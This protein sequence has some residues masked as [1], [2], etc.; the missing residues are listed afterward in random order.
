MTSEQAE[1]ADFAESTSERYEEIALSEVI[2]PVLGKTPKRKD[3]ENWGGDIKWASAKDISQNK[4]RRIHDTE[5]KMT[6]KGK[7]ESNAKI[8]PEGT[9]VVVARGATMGRA[10]QLGEPMTF[11]QTC[12]GLNANSSLDDDFLYYA[13]KYKFN[14]IQAV[15]HGTVFDT[16]TMDSFNDIDI[17][18][19]EKQIQRKIASVLRSIDNKIEVN[20]EIRGILEEMSHTLFKN[21]FVNFSPYGS[22][23]ETDVGKIPAGFQLE[24][25]ED[26]LS[27]QRGYSYSGD[28]LIDEESDI[29][30]TEGYPMVNLGN[31]SPGGGYRPENIKYSKELPKDRYLVEPGDLIISHTDMTQDQDIL[32]SPVI[33]PD[34]EEE[35]IL[36]SHHLYAV[37]DTELPNEF[38]YYYFLSPYF[39]PKAENFA[40]G[41]TV[42]SFSSKITSD[43]QIPIPPKEDI[44]KYVEKVRPMFEKIEE[45]RKE[46][47]QLA[48][49]RDTLLPKLM[50]GEVRVNDISLDELE[51]DSE[52]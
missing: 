32:G 28:D 36:F 26:V 22:F 51:V 42:L 5:E 4:T 7:E 34:F 17:P 25:L 11:N 50:S 16:I 13:W 47:N 37:Q 15:S 9:L 23:K 14:Q 33:V 21:Q 31:V 10:A 38:L 46:N 35:N 27:L 19:P 52:V 49:L 12:Y 3:D 8:M 41:T 48:E 44:Q 20:N 39:K 1:M 29:D 43:V 6:D 40:S 2:E 30:P 24:S 45:I 18:L